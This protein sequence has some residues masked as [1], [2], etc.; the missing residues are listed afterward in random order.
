MRLNDCYRAVL[1]DVGWTLVYPSPRREEAILEA[2]RRRGYPAP[3]ANIER[4]LEAARAFY[5]A[6]RWQQQTK[7]GLSAFWFRYYTE[8]LAHLEPQIKDPNL[9]KDLVEEV[10]G[11]I[12]YRL[13]PDTLG[14]LMELRQ[15]D[16][17]IGAVS[18]WSPELP[19]LCRAWGL[20]PYFDTLVV[21]D[22]VGPHK[23]DPRI[24][25]IALGAL[26]VSAE[27]AIHVGDDYE[28]D[29][30]GA[31]AAGILPVLLD[32]FGRH[33]SAD[34]IRIG[35]LEDLLQLLGACCHLV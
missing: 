21:S 4:G 20:S 23:P 27:E 13:Y 17:A 8:L 30:Q 33:E 28:A 34:C 18:N 24:F 5:Q 12:S 15:R 10:E 1:L 31:R 14:V 25:A 16:F 22:I 35:S 9:A 29:V 2:L 3:R 26:R 19:A 11:A 32:R 6:Q 7:R